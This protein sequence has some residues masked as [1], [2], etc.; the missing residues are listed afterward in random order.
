MTAATR[1]PQTVPSPAAPSALGRIWNV[2]RLHTANPW[3][4]I[5]TPWLVVAAVFGLT[6]AIWRIVQAALGGPGSVDS[7]GFQMSGGISWIIIFMMVVG[8]QAMNL[9]FR[10]A[11][12]YSV[13]R[14]DYYLGSLVYFVL[15][16]LMYGAGIALLSGIEDATGGWGVNGAFFAPIGLV[17]V[18]LWQVGYAYFTLLLMMFGVGIMYG[19]AYVRWRA[20]GVLVFSGLIALLL[21]GAL[22]LVISTD[23]W[24]AVGDFFTDQS[25]VAL[26]SWAL[27]PAA[28]FGL[29][30]YSVLRRATA[31]AD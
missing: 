8:I 14:R 24:T 5:I 25:L 15:L 19:T 6:Y 2:V 17:D 18:P 16:A 10:F 13:T 26:M 11:L 27:V 28:T 3:T 21:V 20:N 30:G 12:G 22:W 7:G 9:T 29:V 4:T 23:S 1:H 31:F